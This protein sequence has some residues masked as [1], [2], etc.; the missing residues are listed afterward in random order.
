MTKIIRIIIILSVLLF[1][2]SLDKKITIYLVGDSTMANKPDPDNNPERGWGQMLPMFFNEN[3]TIKN[4]AVNGRSTKSFIDEGKWEEVISQVKEGDY[5]FMQFGHND[6]KDKDPRRYTNPVTG[7]RYNLE[8]FVNETRNKSGTPVLFSSIVRR[9]FNEFATLVDTHGIY[10]LIVRQVANDLRIPFVDLQLKS[11]QLVNLLGKKKSKEIYLWVEPG[12]YSKYPDGKQDNTH[13]SKKG[14]TMMAQ[15]AVK[16]L[17][18]N[19][20]N[21]NRYLNQLNIYELNLNDN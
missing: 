10:P 6:Q 21:I 15:L 2:C 12:I 18:E 7:Y 19:R 8:K 13:F 17:I 3:V 16:G 20:L 4:Y 1:S 14:A 11:E 5:V 9:K